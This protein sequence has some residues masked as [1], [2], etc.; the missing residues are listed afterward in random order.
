VA[1]LM[2]RCRT[3]GHLAAQAAEPRSAAFLRVPLFLYAAS[4]S[5]SV[6]SALGCDT[7]TDTSGLDAVAASV[8]N[9]VEGKSPGAQERV[10]ASLLSR[11]LRL[12]VHVD[13]ARITRLTRVNGDQLL[14]SRVTVRR[15]PQTVRAALHRMQRERGSPGVTDAPDAA[16]VEALLLTDARDSTTARSSLDPLF[17]RPTWLDLFIGRPVGAATLVRAAALRSRL[18]AAAGDQR[19]A[20]QWAQFVE[21]L[22]WNADPE[23]QPQLEQLRK[24]SG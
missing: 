2:G 19:A 12:R 22:W 6:F 11:P 8:R 20:R 24:I 23:L 7:A 14:A 3:A 13:S 10:E 9:L 16:L 18:A 1:A 15:D 4:E 17:L 21:K 5:L